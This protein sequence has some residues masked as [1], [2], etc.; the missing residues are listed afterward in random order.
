MVAE[1]NMENGVAA[2]HGG[3]AMIKRMSPYWDSH[4]A[5]PVLDWMLSSQ[6]ITAEEREKLGKDLLGETATT[7]A[8]RAAVEAEIREVEAKLVN[9]NNAIEAYKK[10]QQKRIGGYPDRKT[11]VDL[12][13]WWMTNSEQTPTPPALEIGVDALVPRL[14]KLYFD[15]C[16]YKKSLQQLQYMLTTLYELLAEGT[17]IQT[18][19]ACYWGVCAC[20]I[21]LNHQQGETRAAP[22][23]ETVKKDREEELLQTLDNAE[24][25]EGEG[26][27]SALAEAAKKAAETH[28]AAQCILK[29]GDILDQIA[30]ASNKKDHQGNPPLPAGL[31]MSREQQLLNRSWLLHWA[32]WPLFR[33]YFY[34]VH[35]KQFIPRNQAWSLLLEWML[36]E[37]N[38]SCV[39]VMCPHLLRYY[40]VYAILNRKRKDH[41]QA[42]IMAIGQSKNRYSDPFTSLLEAL[43]LDFNF[44]EAQLHIARIGEECD[45]DFFLQPLKRA[46]NEFARLLIF[47]TYC[48]IHKCINV[49]MIAKKVNMSPEAAERWIV[50]LIRHARLE[51]RIDSEKNRV[52][53]SA[54]PPNLYQQ[55]ID[56]TR[57]LCIRSNLILQNIARPAGFTGRDGE[58]IVPSRTNRQRGGRGRQWVQ[59]GEGGFYRGEGGGRGGRGRGDRSHM[60]EGRRDPMAAVAASMAS[61]RQD[62]TAFAA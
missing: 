59:N 51:A 4:M 7:P 46:I 12:S 13:E 38:L 3:S 62:D 60:S 61:R 42:V 50:N 21:L 6:M 25:E 17:N 57:N 41:F 2:P 14:A 20:I 26:A 28:A 45:S 39:T 1:P 36:H 44:D 22:T 49:D 53:M 23:E 30:A 10:E 58:D 5:I 48:R 34:M 52:Q 56:K 15:I 11:L 16:D 55:V 35:T 54:A 31:M 40:A 33:Y 19:M 29:L 32:V 27:S 9:F 24:D 47:E 43:F 37:G 18:R 8:G